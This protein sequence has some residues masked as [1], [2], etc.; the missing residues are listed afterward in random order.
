MKLFNIYCIKPT[1]QI[2]LLLV[3]LSFYFTP[4]VAQVAP[5]RITLKDAKEMTY[6]AQSTVERL[7]DLLYYIA[8]EDNP[9]S[10]LA[11]VMKDS[12]TPTKN[13]VFVD[14]NSIVED[15]TDPDFSVKTAKNIDAIKYLNVFDLS[16]G[17]TT[18]N[19]ISFTK[20]LISKIKKKEYL[21]VKVRF[22]E[23][24]GG[25]YKPNGKTYTPREREAIVQLFSLGNNRW[26]ALI[27]GLNF[28]NSATDSNST[29]EDV[30]IITDASPTAEIVSQEDFAKEKAD[31][32]LAKQEEEK[33]NQA[34]FDEYVALGNSYVLNRQYKEALDFYSRAKEI[35]SLVPSLDKRILDTKKLASEYTFESL[36]SRADQA[37]GERRYAEAMQNY[38]AAISLKPEAA[39][40]VAG[41]IQFITKKLGEIS[42]PKNKL[43]AGDYLGAI[44]ASENILKENKK[45][46]SDFSELYYIKGQAYESLAIK[47]PADAQ[48]NQEKALENYNTAIEYFPN[49]LEARLSRA[50]FYANVKHDYNNAI[51]DY[52]VVTSTALDT[53]P[54]K[55][56]YLITKG[57]WKNQSKNYSG[58]LSDFSKA[59]ALNPGVS[60]F[61]FDKGELL[62]RLQRYNEALSSFNAAIKLDSKNRLAYYYRGLTYE[63]MNDAPKAGEDFAAAE[64]LGIE[65]YQL[66]K[67]VS[68]ST[69]YFEAGR[70]A[71]TAR[72][73]SKADTLFNKAIAIRQCNPQAWHGKAEIRLTQAGEEAKNSSSTAFRDKYQQAIDLY[74][75]AINC[76]PKYSD[77]FYKIG[78]AYQRTKQFNQALKGYSNAINSDANNAQAYIGRGSTLMD[79]KQYPEAITDLSNA[80][81]L[82]DFTLQAAKK[83]S[84]KEIITATNEQLSRV[85][86]LQS[87][88]W[89]S[90]GDYAKAITSADKALEY[91]EKNGEALYYKGQASEGIKDVSK[92]LKSYADAIR[93]APHFK[94]FYANGKALLGQEKYDVAISNF[95]QAIKFDTLTTIRSSRYLR[96]LSYFKNKMLDPAYKDFTEYAKHTDS[97]DSLFYIDFGMLNLYMNHDAAA[98]ENFQS[99]LTIKPNQPRALFGLG[100]AYAKAG[101]FDNA[102]QQFAL[103]YAT[104]RLKKEEVKL[105]EEAFL[106]DFNKVKAMRNQYAQLK[107]NY[108]SISN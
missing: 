78:V 24:F 102:M 9:P 62:Y 56:Q 79:M 13:Q 42:L 5:E 28:Y 77:A 74:Q 29:E 86:Q 32:V 92:A 59:I 1:F 16:Y 104:R 30:Q 66:Q 107:K 50:N 103:A 8:S 84:Q 68:I 45:A 72:K 67:I 3:S 91:D 26:K 95:T 6:Q 41:D 51:T 82:L 88:A 61:W 60:S 53:S 7:Q 99:A 21:Y 11:S 58:A 83:N 27:A 69:A 19:N 35:H 64:K 75:K 106:N 20:F 18:D 52:D 93:Y 46:K 96:G 38:Q 101:K 34:T 73:F 15:D 87:Q 47:Q 70:E 54:E 36:K 23:N 4:S 90:K 17:K 14:G 40:S 105:D 71:S 85:Y 2:G 65:P 57:K 98:I 39:T 89:Y 63:S 81:R 48:R 25:T 22:Q 55:P 76:N 12:Y 33:R 97:S 108:L 100:C 43:D 31:F 37:K 10:E 49:Y 94:Y 44:E 80:A